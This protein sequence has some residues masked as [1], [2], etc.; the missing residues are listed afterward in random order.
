M[1]NRITYGETELKKSPATCVCVINRFP[2]K[3]NRWFSR[4]RFLRIFDDFEEN[5]GLWRLE[6]EEGDLKGRERE[7]L[8][9]NGDTEEWGDAQ[10]KYGMIKED[11]EMQISLIFGFGKL[12]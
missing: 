3:R 11:L 2:F 5:K 8:I 7:V 1:R 6:I 9:F 10:K 4:R 12:R